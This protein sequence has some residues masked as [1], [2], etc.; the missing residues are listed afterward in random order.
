M[1]DNGLQPDFPPAATEQLR[2]ISG[3]AVTSDPQIRDLSALLW[4]SIDNDDSLDLDQLS[5][6]E[7]QGNGAVKILVAV[8]DVDA[9]IASGS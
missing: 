5:V 4:C 6:A 7:P 2:N 8:A 1:L 3:P 9:T